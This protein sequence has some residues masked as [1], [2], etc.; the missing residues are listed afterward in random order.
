MTKN[1][2]FAVSII[3]ACFFFIQIN[4]TFEYIAT[5]MLF[6]KKSIDIRIKIL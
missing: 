3:A 4:E 1:K 6:N 5:E 2:Y